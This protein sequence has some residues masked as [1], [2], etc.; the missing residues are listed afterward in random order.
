MLFY[1]KE[2][3]ILGSKWHQEAGESKSVPIY[4]SSMLLN[5]LISRIFSDIKQDEEKYL[6]YFD[7]LILMIMYQVPI[8]STYP[9][10]NV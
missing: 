5:N 9:F 6:N 4:L 10:T 1:G 2:K 7:C 8:M 3:T